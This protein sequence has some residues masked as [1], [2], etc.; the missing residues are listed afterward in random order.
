MK[1]ISPLSR[2]ALIVIALACANL[3]PLMAQKPFSNYYYQKK[4]LFEKLPKQADDI[5]FL[6]NS[7]TDGCEWSELLADKRI[8]NRGISGDVTQGVLERLADITV[9]KP[10]KIFLMIG[11]NDL[12]RGRQPKAIV[13]D[14]RR[15]AERIRTESPT[16]KLYIESVLPMTPY[17][18]GPAHYVSKCKQVPLINDGLKVMAK[19][20]GLTYVDL[21]TAF[22]DDKG[23]MKKELTNDGLHLMAP[24]Y[25]LWKELITPYVKE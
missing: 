16:T 10:A 4:S 11:I 24:G 7:I 21:Y 22:V 15:I 9:G 3:L 14:I 18:H 23:E 1:R 8:K 2:L 6:G 19:E 13:Q 12:G 25:L 17:H 20:M 5:I